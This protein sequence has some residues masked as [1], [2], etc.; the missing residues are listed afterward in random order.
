MVIFC[1]ELQL[2]TVLLQ[3]KHYPACVA[4]SA[5]GLV[6]S[7][8]VADVLWAAQLQHVKANALA[9]TGDAAEAVNVMR[10]AMSR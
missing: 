2:A 10:D 7:S 1:F 6:D 3:L 5:R 8:K 4:V 9:A